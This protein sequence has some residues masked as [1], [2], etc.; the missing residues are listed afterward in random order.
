MALL[1]LH[2]ASMPSPMDASGCLQLGR[3]DQQNILSFL[4]V[5]EQQTMQSTPKAM[6]YGRRQHSRHHTHVD[7]ADQ[8]ALGTKSQDQRSEN[9][10]FPLI[11]K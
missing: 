7:N 1:V 10:W 4:R 5:R 3:T 11:L 6:V 8:R 2:K 9:L